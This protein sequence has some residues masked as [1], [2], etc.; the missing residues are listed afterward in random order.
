M[1]ILNIH[2]FMGESDNKNYKAL[3][4]IFGKE[5][6]ISPNLDYMSDSPEK[7]LSFLSDMVDSDD[8]IFVGQSL[9]GWYADKLSRKFH[10]PCVLTNPCSFPHKTSVIQES[11]LS[12]NFIEEYEKMS[13]YKTNTLS[14]VLCSDNDS[15][16]TDNLKNCKRL[17]ENITEVKGSHSTIENLGFHLKNAFDMLISDS[18][19]YF[20]GRGSAF[21]DENNSAFFIQDNDLV[22]ID[23]PAGTFHKAKK[24]NLDKDIYVLVTHTH[25]DHVSGVGTML[26]YVWFAKNKKL[27]VVAPSD[28]V[29]KDL[30]YQL[31]HIEGCNEEWFNITSANKLNKKWL[32]S[33]VPTKHSDE[34]KGRC[35]GYHLNVN[36][37]NT[38]Y[39]GDT[40]I[41][42]PFENL[43]DGNTFLYTEIASIKSGVH[44][45]APDILPKL[46]KLSE[47][48]T[49]V[50][51]MHMDNED[52]IRE[53]TA[54]TNL[55]F[56]PLYNL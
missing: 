22:F 15:V 53:L 16:I 28:E 43:I 24:M 23:C 29:E 30:K 37:K 19:M 38:V 33:S 4:D 41:F 2:G 51:L 44:L 17:S 1:R 12:E 48:G 11:E 55:R 25:G 50:Y 46:K 10:R 18:N 42:E 27:T 20:F 31:M 49:H 6:V 40:R 32:V 36:G 13:E 45:Y 8:F 5:S 14:Y 34:L 39:T 54:G 52:K 26:Q 21:A 3:C 47:N 35:F 56:V 9:G 7:I